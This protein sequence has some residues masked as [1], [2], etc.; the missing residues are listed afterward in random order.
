MRWVMSIYQWCNIQLPAIVQREC[1]WNLWIITSS[2]NM[3]AEHTPKVHKI[4]K[5]HNTYLYCCETHTAH[6]WT[7][8]QKQPAG[9]WCHHSFFQSF[10][11]QRHTLP[12]NS[13]AV[14]TKICHVFELCR[15]TIP[16][17]TKP[18]QTKDTDE[19]TFCIGKLFAMTQRTKKGMK[20]ELVRES[21]IYR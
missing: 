17:H 9:V 11:Q 15:K 5:A 12:S 1:K 21:A 20:T 7:W 14:Y 4:H 16:W 13:V 3:L 18:N 8:F 2:K 6:I 10:I 19:H